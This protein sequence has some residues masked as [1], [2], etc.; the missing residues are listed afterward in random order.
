M[1]I[2]IHVCLIVH[3]SLLLLFGCIV[4]CKVITWRPYE[5]CSVD[6]G[7]G[8]QCRVPDITKPAENGG[9]ECPEIDCKTCEGTRCP[10]QSQNITDI[11]SK[12]GV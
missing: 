2:Y 9:E 12:G 8:R 4:D 11:F 1:F 5:E 10:G 3:L 6:C 7:M